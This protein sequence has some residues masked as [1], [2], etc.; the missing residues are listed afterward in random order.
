MNSLPE[1]CETI[2]AA[3]MVAA[4]AIFPIAGLRIALF[5]SSDQEA[6]G[7]SRPLRDAPLGNPANILFR[8]EL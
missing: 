1:P 3:A 4:V 5:G 8:R 2:L 6:M 7:G